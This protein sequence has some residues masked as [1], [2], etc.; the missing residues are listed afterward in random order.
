MQKENDNLIKLKMKETDWEVCK[1]N[2]EI[3]TLQKQKVFKNANLID[4]E[5]GT[6]KLVDI[7]VTNG[8]VKEIFDA[9]EHEFSSHVEILDLEK[10]FVM[11]YFTNAFTNRKKILNIDCPLGDEAI[12][13]CCEELMGIKDVLAGVLFYC[14][15]DYTEKYLL[16]DDDLV[17]LDEKDLNSISEQ[18]AKNNGL[19]FL[20]VG[21]SLEALG[22]IHK[23]FGKALPY[24]LE[25]FGFLDR[26]WVL[27]GGNCLEKDDLQTFL[28][29]GDK[30]VICPYEDAQCGRRATNLMTLNQLGFDISIGSGF[31]Y[32]ID[33]F[34]FV[35]QILLN[36]WGM[37][38]DKN[39]LSEKDVLLM[40]TKGR[41]TIRTGEKANFIVIENSTNLYENI[42]KKL[43]WG[44]SKKD[45][46]L[47]IIE[48]RILQNCGRIFGGI[49]GLNQYEL[50]EKIKKLKQQGEIKK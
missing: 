39:C 14:D 28:Q 37:F 49:T 23:K 12:S 2:A 43:V 6:F 41:S 18:V 16:E 7:F 48:G 31:S 42:L 46:T 1:E 26:E 3:K 8:I 4:I 13:K 25:D 30:F 33:F 44:T 17:E 50:I 11:T 22:T 21:Q 35:R 24:V 5:S 45:I 29:Y 36:H 10:D 34:G 20:K 9:G 47:S 38:E 27:V 40:A 15:V 32:E 19:L